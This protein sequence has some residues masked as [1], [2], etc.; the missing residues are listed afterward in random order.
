MLSARSVLVGGVFLI[1]ACS[2][3]PVDPSHRS[4]NEAELAPP[5]P[6]IDYAVLEKTD[7]SAV[8]VEYRHRYRY[9]HRVDLDHLVTVG[10]GRR[11]GSRDRPRQGRLR[12]KVS[13]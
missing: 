13:D 1:G 6:S 11:R 5:E 3:F 9:Q 4:T 10:L 7:R 2:Q 12:G 8:V